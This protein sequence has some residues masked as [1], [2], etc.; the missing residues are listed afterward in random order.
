[1]NEVTWRENYR[2]LSAGVRMIRETVEKA[3]GPLAPLPHP[4]RIGAIPEDCDHISKAIM[5]YAERTQL[6]IAG[7][8][9]ALRASEEARIAA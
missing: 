5:L 8:E 6:R 7:L 4:E 9:A 1:M 3:F 2:D